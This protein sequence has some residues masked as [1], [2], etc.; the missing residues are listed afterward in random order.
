[1]AISASREHNNID[2]RNQVQAC[3]WRVYVE[4]PPRDAKLTFT[5]FWSPSS[6]L[7]RTR[8]YD[9]VK[10]LRQVSNGDLQSGHI[11]NHQRC[12]WT[13]YNDVGRLVTQREK[14]GVSK[15]SVPDMWLV[16]TGRGRLVAQPENCVLMK[17]IIPHALRAGLR[18]VH[19]C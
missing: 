4:G 14:A 17:N 9:M 16:F 3:T 7:L 15:T 6:S 2:S 19:H 11:V 13:P 5:V 12:H 10:T 8:V 1:M 18:F